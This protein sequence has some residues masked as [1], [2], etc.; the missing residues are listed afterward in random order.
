MSIK[1]IKHS[2]LFI[3]Q[4]AIGLWRTLA[5]NVG[6]TL[7]GNVFY[8]ACQW[9]ILSVIARLLS[10]DAVGSFSLA[11]A[12][13]SPIIVFSQLQLR[14]VL[15]TDTRA[16][17]PISDYLGIR[18]PMTGLALLVVFLLSLW[19]KYG[20][21]TKEVLLLVACAKGAE[22]VSDCLYGLM[23]QR[24]Q[25]EYMGRSLIL[26]GAASLL[27]V[28][29]GI[30][31]TH[32]LLI[33]T[34]G[35][36]VTWT[37]VLAIY[38]VRVAARLLADDPRETGRWA[39][40]RQLI[41]TFTRISAKGILHQCLP[42]GVSSMLYTLA[43]NIPRYALEKTAGLH[44]LGIYSALAYVLVGGAVVINA[45]GT[46]AVPVLAR[47]YD[48]RH[49]RDY[50]LTLSALASGTLLLGIGVT[51]VCTVFGGSLLQHLYGAEYARFT[52]AFGWIMA[53]GGVTY[54][55]SILGYGI[56]ATRRFSI[57]V[58]LHFIITG[59]IY[60]TCLWA[61]PRYNIIGAAWSLIAGA[62]I[63]SVLTAAVIIQG[64]V[65]SRAEQI[66]PLSVAA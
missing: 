32:S 63:A 16:L 27:V 62:V 36:L 42:L 7:V 2:G 37:A 24:L 48:A 54:F 43:P 39:G 26:K 1:R 12:I 23:Q 5:Q 56:V 17:T 46:A 50:A 65:T 9:G 58:P 47:Q 13:T 25:M 6:W 44:V 57:Q 59:A 38:D 33:G 49:Y 61:I 4:T 45:V 41:P 30:W 18:L 8:A 14:S 51:V 31:L 60:L 34:L 11:L 19:S 10:P 22:S 29:I 35:L 20:A 53:A 15:A 28:G 40:Y 64:I 55:A 66:R 21:T 52:T 3:L